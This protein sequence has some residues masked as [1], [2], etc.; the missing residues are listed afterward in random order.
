M[1]EAPAAQRKAIVSSSR[2]LFLTTGLK[3][4]DPTLQTSV[5]AKIQLKSRE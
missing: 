1:V 2:V 5:F 4:Q 3:T